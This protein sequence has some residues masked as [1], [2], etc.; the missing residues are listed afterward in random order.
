MTAAHAIKSN[1]EKWMDRFANEFEYKETRETFKRCKQIKS[2]IGFMT[3]NPD[4]KK[5]SKKLSQYSAANK[6][7]YAETEHM[8]NLASLRQ[9]I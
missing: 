7:N 9:R 3:Q 6:N 5:K 4:Y 8:R 2:D 1:E